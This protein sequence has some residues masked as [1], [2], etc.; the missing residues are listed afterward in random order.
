[1]PLILFCLALPDQ[2]NNKFFLKQ[3]KAKFIR[4]WLV[5]FDIT[6]YLLLFLFS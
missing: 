2:I 4:Q 3:Q 5:G 1:M 6:D